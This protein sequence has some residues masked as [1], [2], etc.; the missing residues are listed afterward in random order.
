MQ[1]RIDI[2]NSKLR[3]A[4]LG[5]VD[6]P[7]FEVPGCTRATLHKAIFPMVDICRL[8][9][10]MMADILWEMHKE[11]YMYHEPEESYQVADLQYFVH[12]ITEEEILPG[13]LV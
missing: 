5:F 2:Q 1:T 8:S 13:A 3:S 11:V 7:L 6:Y 12:M 10:E 4:D 9:L